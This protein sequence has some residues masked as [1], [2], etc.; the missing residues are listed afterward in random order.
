MSCN[1]FIVEG[2]TDE[3]YL[4]YDFNANTDDGSC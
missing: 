1:N 3:N 2:C 4:E